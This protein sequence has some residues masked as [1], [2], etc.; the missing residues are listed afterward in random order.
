MDHSGGLPRVIEAVKPARG[1]RLAHGAQGA[2]RRTSTGDQAV[3]SVEGRRA[4][5]RWA[6][7]PSRFVETPHAALARQHVH[8]TSP[9]SGCS[10]RRTRSA[11]TS[12]AAS[13]S[14]TRST[15]AVLR[16]EA[17]KYYANILMPYSP[18]VTKP[19]RAAAGRWA[20]PDASSRRTTGRSGARTSSGSSARTRDWAAQQPARKAV[21][22]YDT[23]WESTA[24]MARA[25]GDGLAAGGASVELLPLAAYHRSDIATELLDAG[26]LL[27]G[28]PTLNN[29]IFPTRR[30]RADLPEGPQA[31]ATSSARPSASYGW[32]GEAARPAR[33]DAR[34]R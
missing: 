30:R 26:A 27:V 6:T 29:Q 24:L 18:V 28:S 25:I 9:R 23:M 19:A 34:G 1:R 14:T 22:V 8:A 10:S 7:A 15:R 32:S 12:P 21:V 5:R 4:P 11:C 13:A 31:A 33:R 17:A 16:D 20:R 2:A 3:R